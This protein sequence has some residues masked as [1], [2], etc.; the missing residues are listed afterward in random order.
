MYAGEDGGTQR[1]DLVEAAVPRACEPT[2]DVSRFAAVRGCAHSPPRHRRSVPMRLLLSLAL[3][4][5]LALPVARSGAEERRAAHR[6]RPRHGGRVL[7]RQGREDAEHRRAGEDRHAVHARVR[8]RCRRAAR[9]GPRCSPGCRRTR[10]GMYGLAHATHNQHSFRTVQRAAGAARPGR[11]TERSDREV[12]RSAEGGVPVRR[13]DRGQ[14]PQPGA[15][16]GAGQEVHRGLRRQAVLPAGRASPTRTAPRRASPTTRKYPA[17]VPAVKFDPKTLPVPYHLPDTPE[18]RADLADYYQ[19]VA[20]LDHGVG[21]VLKVLEDAKQLDDTLV[22]FLSDNGIPFPGAKTTLYDAGVHLPLVI[23]KPGQK[24][25]VTNSAMVSWTDITPTVLDWCGVK[26]TGG[27][28]AYDCRAVRSC[29][30]W[31]R[32]SRRAGTWCSARTS[33]TKSRC[34]T[35]CGWCARGRTSIILNLAHA[36]EY[37]SAWTC[38]ARDRGRAF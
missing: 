12:A 4:L 19:S 20:R 6:R 26:P 7:R 11:A 2:L 30:C 29:R 9:A 17:E 18:V 38:G 15:D 22:I 33:S 5:A 32:R 16:R 31:R 10:T 27:K 37:P 14:R 24:A 1:S 21:L 35:R 28:K 25:G 36:L 13:G 23:R 3:T 34:T 8:S